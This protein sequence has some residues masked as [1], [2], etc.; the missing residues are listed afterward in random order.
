MRYEQRPDLKENSKQLFVEISGNGQI[1]DDDVMP[2][3]E[4]WTKWS[5]GSRSVRARNAKR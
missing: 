3:K 5:V 2:P 1:T 4:A